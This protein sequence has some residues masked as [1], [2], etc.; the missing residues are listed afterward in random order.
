MSM[1]I[2]GIIQKY[3][4]YPVSYGKKQNIMDGFYDIKEFPFV[5]D[6]VD[7]TLIRNRVPSV[8]E[9]LHVCRKGY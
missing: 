2:A 3:I 8:D 6:A 7:E 9:H 5:L 1:N 4:K